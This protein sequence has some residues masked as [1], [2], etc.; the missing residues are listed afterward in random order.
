M[1]VAYHT[2]Q[3]PRR[4]GGHRQIEAPSPELKAIQRR[5][6]HRLLKRLRAHPAVTGFER[7][8]SIVTNAVVHEGQAVVLRMDLRSF[9]PSTPAQRITTYL[10]RIGWDA[11]AASIITRLCTYE[12]RLPQG[13]PTSPRLS[14]LVN[15]PLDTRLYALARRYRATYT[16]YADDLTFSFAQ[17]ED[18][19][20]GDLIWRASAIV[21]FYGYKLHRRRKLNV[22][23]AHQ[24]QRVTGLVV[25]QKTNLPRS[26]RRWL[27][28]VEH[29]IKT[30][31]PATLNPAQLAGW[32][33]LASMVATQRERAA[34]PSTPAEP[35]R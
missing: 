14:N 9:F 33:S 7:H 3:I 13:A 25:N 8:H 5:I 31:R 2:F 24:Q 32:K 17:D 29:H 15:Y 21:G 20:V 23:R 12:G 28:A 16:R 1:P 19:R 10:R 27:R 6:L 35:A 18:R 34:S 11:D 26:T 4:G 30:G 22:R